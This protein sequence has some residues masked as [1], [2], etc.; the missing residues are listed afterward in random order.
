[1]IFEDLQRE[2]FIAELKKSYNLIKTKIADFETESE[3][4]FLRDH[5][6]YYYAVKEAVEAKQ[7]THKN[8]LIILIGREIPHLAAKILCSENGI[9]LISYKYID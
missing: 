2:K 7:M 6:E 8:A 9:E 4:I 3:I 5:N 1:M